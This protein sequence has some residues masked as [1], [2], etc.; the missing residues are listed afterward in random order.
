VP[1]SRRGWLPETSARQ[2]LSIGSRLPRSA[3]EPGALDP[4]DLLVSAS[5]SY[6]DGYISGDNDWNAWWDFG[7]NPDHAGRRV[8]IMLR[9]GDNRIVVRVRNGQFASGGFFAA[10]E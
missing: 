5:L 2:V 4:S 9:S 10:I 1:H 3:D 7:N 8:P 6:R